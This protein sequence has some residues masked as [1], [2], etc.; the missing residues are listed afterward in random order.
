VRGKEEE[1]ESCSMAV[2]KVP[3]KELGSAVVLVAKNLG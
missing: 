3:A 2:G 1:K